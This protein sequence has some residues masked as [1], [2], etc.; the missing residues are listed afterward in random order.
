VGDRV[1]TANPP[2]VIHE[3]ERL[4]VLKGQAFLDLIYDNSSVEIIHG[5]YGPILPT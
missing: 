3:S 5:T 4:I 2:L 1:E